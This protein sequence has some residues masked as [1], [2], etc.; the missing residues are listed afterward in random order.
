MEEWEIYCESCTKILGRGWH[1]GSPPPHGMICGDCA[2]E[3]GRIID[4]GLAEA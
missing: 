4:C 2:D 3:T 1:E